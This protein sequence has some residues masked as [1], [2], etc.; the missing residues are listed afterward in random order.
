MSLFLGKKERKK[1]GKFNFVIGNYD[2]VVVYWVNS[3]CC[4]CIIVDV[5]WCFFFLVDE[6]KRRRAE[7]VEVCGKWIEFLRSSSIIIGVGNR[8]GI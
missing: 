1:E 6:K 8:R 4:V 7:R 2:V 5:I 3:I